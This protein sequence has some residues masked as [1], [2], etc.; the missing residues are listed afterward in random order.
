MSSSPGLP[1]RDVLLVSAIITVSLSVTVVLCGLCHWCQRKLVR[2]WGRGPA[3]QPPT[4]ISCACSEARARGSPHRTHAPSLP[5]SGSH[6]SPFTPRATH[7]GTRT[8]LAVRA[9]MPHSASRPQTHTRG[10]RIASGPAPLVVGVAGPGLSA[11][12]EAQP[13]PSPQVGVADPGLAANEGRR[14]PRPR[15]PHIHP[16]ARVYTSTNG[17]FSFLTRA[18]E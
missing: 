9:R 17:C 1:T 16:G 13:A 2:S 18:G 5:V 10:L 6:A 7:P 4:Q 15:R 12:E 8:L 14:P 3:L 11:N